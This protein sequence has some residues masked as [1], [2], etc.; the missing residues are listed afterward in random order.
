MDDSQ[1]RCKTYKQ[2]INSK[3][4]NRTKPAPN[5][6]FCFIKK[7]HRRSLLEGIRRPALLNQPS[8]HRKPVLRVATTTILSFLSCPGYY[9]MVDFN[10]SFINQENTNKEFYCSL[11]WKD[12]TSCLI[13]QW[14]KFMLTIIECLRIIYLHSSSNSSSF[15]FWSSQFPSSSRSNWTGIW[16]GNSNGIWTDKQSSHFSTAKEMSVKATFFFM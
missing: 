8:L 1:K 6:G 10:Y 11:W 15:T 7:A 3:L 16:T 13:Q 2:S 5:I 9:T 4:P 14:D 12:C